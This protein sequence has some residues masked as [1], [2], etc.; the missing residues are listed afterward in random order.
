[1]FLHKLTHGRFAAINLDKSI[2]LPGYSEMCSALTLDDE[3]R[4]T[5]LTACLLKL[6]LQVNVE[7]NTVPSLSRLHLSSFSPPDL[8]RL[9]EVLHEVITLHDGEEYLKDDNDTFHFEKPS[10]WAF[11]SLANALTSGVK[12]D[13]DTSAPDLDR[14]IDYNAIVKRVIVHNTTPPAGK[15][16]PYFNHDAFYAN[17]RHYASQGPER[18]IKFGKMLLYGDVVTSTNTMLEKL[19]IPFHSIC[20][21]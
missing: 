9:M 2:D 21:N 11:G 7:N 5:F 20:N 13:T 10:T 8:A 12:D 14:D 4:A 6:G 18:E 17:L 15:E 3:K 16:T 19:V 1:M